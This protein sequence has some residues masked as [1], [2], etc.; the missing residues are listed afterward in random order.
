M[1]LNGMLL[2][3]QHRMPREK[4]IVAQVTVELLPTV[5]VSF[6]DIQLVGLCY[7]L[8]TRGYTMKTSG[9]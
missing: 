5:D 9:I 4:S 1:L 6:T 2:E 7:K 8:L 3:W